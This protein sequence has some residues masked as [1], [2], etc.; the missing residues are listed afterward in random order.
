MNRPLVTLGGASINGLTLLTSI[1]IALLTFVLARVLEKGIVRYLSREGVQDEGSAG[2]TG[3]LIYYSVLLVGFS[4][5]IHT[6]GINL[7]AFFAA[8][9]VFAI[10]LGFAMQNITQNFVSGL[11]LLVERTIKPGDIIEVEG[12]MVR[13]TKLGM[14]ATVT[15][16]WDS[17]DYIIPNSVLVSSTVK[18][19][20]LR[21]RMYRIRTTV[22][23]AYESDMN[24]V[25]EVL[26]KAT[27]GIEWRHPS[28]EPVLLMK[29]FGTSSVDF[30]VSVW[31]DDPFARSK[32]QS[33]L[34]QVVWWALKDAGITIA[35]PQLDVHYEPPKAEAAPQ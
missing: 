26:L 20:T 4:V 24:Q 5:A 17:E 29:Q 35:F 25:F 3:R 13:V 27:E 28:K 14:R 30:D 6:L 10:A 32:S 11:I 7:T 15:R 31:V 33:D 16:T 8:G 1:A 18:N 34:N 19:F 23:V 21:D 9:A 22:G 2:A 12:R